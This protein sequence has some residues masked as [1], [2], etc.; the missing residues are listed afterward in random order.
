[1]LI[2]LSSICSWLKFNACSYTTKPFSHCHAVVCGAMCNGMDLAKLSLVLCS[3]RKLKTKHII[4]H[5]FFEISWQKLLFTWEN[6]GP[7]DITTLTFVLWSHHWWLDDD[8]FKNSLLRSSKLRFTFNLMHWNLESFYSTI[9][10]KDD[11]T[12]NMTKW[13]KT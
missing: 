5:F 8:S 2:M 13:K 9:Y 7:L 4:S 3:E 10:F 12:G 11:E 6:L 1:M